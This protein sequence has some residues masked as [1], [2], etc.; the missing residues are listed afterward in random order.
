MAELRLAYSELLGIFQRDLG[1]VV[2][3]VDRNLGL[4]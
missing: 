2:D 3:L 4:P 1:H